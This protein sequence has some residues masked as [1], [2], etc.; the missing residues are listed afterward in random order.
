MTHFHPQPCLSPGGGGSVRLSDSRQLK[1]R[2]NE[3]AQSVPS[4]AL[5][6]K[7]ALRRAEWRKFSVGSDA[8]VRMDRCPWWLFW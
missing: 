8:A 3:R 1:E 4:V 7:L 2:L 5:R 6:L